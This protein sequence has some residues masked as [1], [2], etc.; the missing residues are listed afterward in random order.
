MCR[1]SHAMEAN[2][3][4]GV[5]QFLYRPPA[6]EGSRPGEPANPVVRLQRLSIE[7][8][9]DAYRR[10]A[11]RG[12][13]DRPGCRTP[14]E[15]LGVE[16]RE[17][18]RTPL[19][20][21]VFH[22]AYSGKDGGTV[23]SRPALFR[24]YADVLLGDHPALEH[25][26]AEVIAHLVRTKRAVVGAEEAN[27]IVARWWAGANVGVGARTALTPVEDLVHAGLLRRGRGRG[28]VFV[29]SAC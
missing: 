9:G 18:L 11:A 10:Y 7:E 21:Y 29:F 1:R 3:F 17:L 19:L 24:A 14:W 25:A 27:D 4:T 8:A 2:P 28:F 13:V 6:E 20:L 22:R 12:L 15:E 26:C 23:G 16:V 5:A